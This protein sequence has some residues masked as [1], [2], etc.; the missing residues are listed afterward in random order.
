MP[1]AG[2]AAE[3]LSSG[4]YMQADRIILRNSVLIGGLIIVFAGLVYVFNPSPLLL[5]IVSDVFP[6]LLAMAGAVF[7][8]GIYRRQEKTR[9]GRRIWGGMTSGLIL[10]TI[11][12]GIWSFYE[13]VLQQETPFPSLAD[14]VWTIGYIPLIYALAAQYFPLRA[15]FDAPR[16]MSIFVTVGIMLVLTLWLVIVPILAD[17]EA[18]TPVEMFFALAYPVGDILLL[19]FA[20]AL[21]AAFLG[22]ELGEA[23]GPIAIGIILLSVADLLFS[24][25][26]WNGL[27]YPEGNLNFLSGLFDML[28]IA[29]Y[30]V[31]TVGLYRRLQLPEVGADLAP[32]SAEEKPL[33]QSDLV[34]RIV[35]LAEEEEKGQRAGQEDPLRVYANAVIGLLDSLVSHAGGARVEG[36]F[37]AVLNEKGR[38]LGCKVEIQKGMVIWQGERPDPAACAELLEEAIRYSKTIVP[39]TTID[40]NLMAVE[41]SLPGRIVQ[42]AEEG[43]LR[44][45]RWLEEKTG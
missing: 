20:V 19:S 38:R 8:Y 22:G 45:V 39:A 27:Y 31:W 44:M 37:N 21:A 11:G 10:W 41:H 43:R 29:A 14:V 15:T 34:K 6:M 30:V 3:G 42:A 2:S 35:E 17:P 36:A 26:N 18:G 7:A 32:R 1:K 25:G 16:R 4:G 24:Y 13:L 28:Y 40:R 33:A 23:W 5:K 9:L 12:E